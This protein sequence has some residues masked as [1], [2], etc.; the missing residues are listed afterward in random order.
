MFA[1]FAALTRE[2]ER[3]DTAILAWTGQ[4]KPEWLASELSYRAAADGHARLLP[5]WIAAAHLFQH[6]THHR[7]QVAT[8]LKQAG[9]DPGVTDLPW[10]P[11]IVR[12][13]D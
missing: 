1:D 10:M 6:A 12:I 5:S 9:K 11:G 2:R 13:V 3:T 4:L 7:G 8:L